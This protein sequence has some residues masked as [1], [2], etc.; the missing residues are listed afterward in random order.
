MTS[1]PTTNDVYTN[2]ERRLHQP[3]Y[4]ST[5]TMEDVY[6][7]HDRRLHQ[8]WKTS[9]PTMTDVYTNLAITVEIHK[10]TQALHLKMTSAK[11]YHVAQVVYCNTWNHIWMNDLESHRREDEANILVIFYASPTTYSYAWTTTSS[12]TSLWKWKSGFVENALETFV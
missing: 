9:T 12:E 3:L 6:T 2:N 5:P 8:P 1:T 11:R 4:T 10:E 7:N